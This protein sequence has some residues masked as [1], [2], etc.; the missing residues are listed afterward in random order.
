MANVMQA[1]SI[2]QL[3]RAG[4]EKFNLMNAFLVIPQRS[5]HVMAMRLHCPICI[6]EHTALER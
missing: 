2:I 5:E 6:Y 1:G 3:A 4:R